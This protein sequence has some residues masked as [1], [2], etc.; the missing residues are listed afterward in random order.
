M[1]NLNE[2]QEGHI[3]YELSCFDR[4]Y[5]NLRL[6]LLCTLGGISLFI[7]KI[8]GEKLP[9]VSVFKPFRDQFVENIETF[10]KDK[11]L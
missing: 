5:L 6:P 3:S 10:A 1:P 7:R 4:I 8:L 2:L 9:L 11:K